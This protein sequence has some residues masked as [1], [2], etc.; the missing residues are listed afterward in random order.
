MKM[1]IS[2]KTIMGLIGLCIVVIIVVGC[3]TNSPPPK[4]FDFG[5]YPSD[6]QNIVTNY[7]QKN[8]NVYGDVYYK[9]W[10]SPYKGSILLP[11]YRHQYGWTVQVLISCKIREFGGYGD[12]EFSFILKNDEVIGH[13]CYAPDMA[14]FSYPTVK[15]SGTN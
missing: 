12:Y 7:V 10:I 14:T 9:N 1:N 2:T 8:L 5:E 3:A 15:K 13:Y 4:N 11:L 6:Y